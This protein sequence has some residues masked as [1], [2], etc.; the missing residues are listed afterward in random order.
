MSYLILI[1]HGQSEWNL[2]N[3]FTGWV[4]VNLTKNGEVRGEKSWGSYKTI[5]NIKID[6]LLFINSTKSYQNTLK[7]IQEVF[8]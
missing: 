6:L 5:Q 7:I 1:R 2:D 4:D 8:K 3:R